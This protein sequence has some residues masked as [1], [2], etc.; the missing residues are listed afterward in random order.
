MRSPRD[1]S[2]ARSSCIRYLNRTAMIVAALLG[3]AFGFFGSMPVAGPIAILVFERGLEGR[4]RDG[5]YIACGAAVAEGTYAYLAFWG[6][7]ALLLHYAWL[8]LGS[9]IAATIILTAIGIY[10]LRHRMSKEDEAARKSEHPDSKRSFFLGLTVTALNPTLLATWG[11]TVTTLYSLEIVRFD[12][13]NALP[14]SI[15]SLSGIVCWFVTLL[16]LVDRLNHR[17]SR[18]SVDRLINGMGVAL[19]AIGLA[20]AVRVAV[21]IFA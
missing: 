10:C 17:F 8:E 3:F 21:R 14:F 4:K 15:G 5:L 12:A 9:R 2:L 7:S 16:Y 13:N 20:L 6:F 1:D 11:A 18:K 19:I